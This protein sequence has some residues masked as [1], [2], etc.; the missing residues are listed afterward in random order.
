MTQKRLKSSEQSNPFAHPVMKFDKSDRQNMDYDQ[1]Q[2]L[3]AARLRNGDRSAAE[4]LVD[5]YYKLIY[6]YMRRLGHDEQT[7]EDLTQDCFLNA[8]YHIGQLRDGKALNG[9]IYRIAS[10]VSKLYWRRH[11]GR[12][13]QKS[14]NIPLPGNA[15]SAF[16]QAGQV[17]EVERLNASLNTLPVKLRQVVVLH[18]MQHLTIAEAANA[19]GLRQGTFKSRLNRALKALRKYMEQKSGDQQ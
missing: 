7:S 19:A 12:E 17:E 15:K 16:I 9:W 10:N 18:Y 2:D 14:E 5:G 6:L 3:L 13:V 11:K 4:E 8:W 1:Q